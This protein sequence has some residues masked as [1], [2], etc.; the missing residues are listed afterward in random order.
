M[1]TLNGN[2][3]NDG[4]VFSPEASSLLLNGTGKTLTGNT[5]F[6]DFTVDGSYSVVNSDMTF[7]GEFLVTNTGSYNAGSGVATVNG[8][9][10]NSGYAF[11]SGTTTFTGTTLQTIRLVN[12]MVSTS[13]GIV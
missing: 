4:G 8:D 10:T 11:S 7:N 3:I 1:I 2:W 5:T 6:N 9:F 12:A 13:T